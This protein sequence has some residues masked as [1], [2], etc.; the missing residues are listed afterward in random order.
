MV[1]TLDF[2]VDEFEEMLALRGIVEHRQRLM[3]EYLLVVAQHRGFMDSGDYVNICNR[4]RD[5]AP[6]SSLELMIRGAVQ[7]HL[8]AQNRRTEE[9]RKQ[10]IDRADKEAENQWSSMAEDA[11]RRRFMMYAAY[12][13]AMSFMKN[14]G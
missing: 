11:N 13:N 7:N 12:R 5:G 9:A 2:D 3:S 1:D 10:V 6:F 8:V 4:I 14:I